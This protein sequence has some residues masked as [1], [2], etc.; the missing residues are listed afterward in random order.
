MAS[1]KELKERDLNPRA[2]PA[3]KFLP[4]RCFF[5]FSWIFFHSAAD[6]CGNQQ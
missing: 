2:P 1:T 3:P 4:V 6:L 5:S